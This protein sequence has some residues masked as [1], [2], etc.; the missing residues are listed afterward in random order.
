MPVYEFRC[1]KCTKAF[2]LVRP[3]SKAGAAAKC[4]DDGTK[5]HRVFGAGIIGVG[6]GD[7]F[8]MGDFGGGL[9]DMGGMG[10]GMPGMGGGMPGMPDMGGMGMGD[11]FDF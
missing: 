7:D 4:P 9:P 2:D 1:P 6:S 10:G 11:D 3:R 5:A 8:D